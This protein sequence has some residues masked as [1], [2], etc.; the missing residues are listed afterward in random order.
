MQMSEPKLQGKSLIQLFLERAT[1]KSQQ[2][3]KTQNDAS[4]NTDGG[5]I[6]KNRITIKARQSTVVST[7]VEKHAPSL[8]R[9]SKG[10]FG[11]AAAAWPRGL[12]FHNDAHALSAPPP[13]H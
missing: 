3:L 1:P 2:K 5:R 8:Q 6:A 10:I 4:S 11:R 9:V 13:S 7:P 12:A